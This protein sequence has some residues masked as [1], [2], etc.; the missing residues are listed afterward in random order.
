MPNTTSELHGSSIVGPIDEEGICPPSSEHEKEDEK[1]I[2]IESAL[3][4]SCRSELKG[5]QVK[6]CD[7]TVQLCGNVTSFHMKQ[8]AQETI[9]PLAAGLR[10]DNQLSVRSQ[11][12]SFPT[13]SLQGRIPCV[14]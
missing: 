4:E 3:S 1:R 10:I 2:L 5:V 8:L 7:D 11:S 12:P 14:L 9:R 6:L 13:H